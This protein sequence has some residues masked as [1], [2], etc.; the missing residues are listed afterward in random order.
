MSLLIFVGIPTIIAAVYFFLMASNEY[1]SEARYTVKGAH[2]APQSSELIGMVLGGGGGGASGY[3]DSW[4]VQ[5][6]ILSSD[7]IDALEK[8]IQLRRIYTDKSIDFFSR[9]SEDASKEE[10]IKYYRKRVAVAFD[11]SS[12]ITT[13]TV[14]AYKRQDAKLI[15]DAIIELS[16]V[17]VNR[18]SDRAQADALQLA[19]Q[20]LEQAEQKAIKASSDIKAFRNEQGD[21]N[22]QATA[23]II[24][25]LIGTLDAELAKTNAELAETKTYMRENSPRIVALKTKL[26]ALRD[27]IESEKSKLTG[28][29]GKVVSG[30]VEDYQRLVMEQEFAVKR[31]TSALT[32][33]EA[34]RVQA[35]AKSRYLE[36]IVMP[37]LPE[38]HDIYLGIRN[39]ASVFGIFLLAF[40]IISLGMAA[41]RE[42]SGQ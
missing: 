20:E 1:V 2:S 25:A 21:I 33:F 35:I 36:P 13:L 17:L 6:Y 12:G 9:L 24:L 8:K 42:H 26:A 28:K 5:D 10:F 40:V 15:A 31:Y 11:F 16:E 32:A 3:L 34:A 29:D 19:R 27:Q 23:Q 7:M 38:R 39:V 30:L 37:M 18:I 41:I 22:P 14:R 4:I